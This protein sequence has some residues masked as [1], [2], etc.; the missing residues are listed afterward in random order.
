MS[1]KLL[2]KKMVSI[3]GAIA[4]SDGYYKGAI[5]KAGQVFDYDGLT[6]KDGSLPFWIEA[7]KG[8]KIV[9][10]EVSAKKEVK[11]EAK[12]E[13]KKEESSIDSLV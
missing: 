5:I 7:P 3:K 4:I 11:K 10:V 6:R 2:E 12:K 8:V 1:E 9:K 13:V